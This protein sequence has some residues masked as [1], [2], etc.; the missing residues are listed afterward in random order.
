[1]RRG[2]GRLSSEKRLSGRVVAVRHRVQTTL[3]CQSTLS[4]HNVAAP[5]SGGGQECEAENN[6]VQDSNDGQGD[7]VIQDCVGA[8]GPCG[9]CLRVGSRCVRP[10]FGPCY[11]VCGAIVRRTRLLRLQREAARRAATG[12]LPESAAVR[13]AAHQMRRHP[14][15]VRRRLRW[16]RMRVRRL[17]GAVD[18][19][20]R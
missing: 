1:M 8:F 17:R 15:H 6:A 7:C 4:V 19:V 10:A 3:H 18:P 9:G 5:A 13:G 14:M 20:R 2:R 16:L 11:R 12:D